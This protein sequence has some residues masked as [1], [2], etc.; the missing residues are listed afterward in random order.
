MGVKFKPEICERK[1]AP[2]DHVAVHYSVGDC[3]LI[4]EFAAEYGLL[5]HG[6][7]IAFILEHTAEQG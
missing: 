1:A 2:G 3:L 7:S 4:P 5:T 6:L